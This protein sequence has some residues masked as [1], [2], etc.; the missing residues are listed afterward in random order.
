MNVT[1][2]PQHFQVKVFALAPWPAD[3]GGAIQVFHRWI[4]QG[5]LP[6]ML[7]DVAD[8]HHVPAG[9]GILLVAH[10]AHYS[11]D[12]RGNRLGLQYARRAALEGTTES[13]LR[14]AIDAAVHACRRLE[15]EPEFAGRLRFNTGELEIRVNDRLLAPNIAQTWEA[16][17]PAF[18]ACLDAIWGCGG[19]RV[20]HS[21]DAREL[22]T[23]QATAGD[24][25]PA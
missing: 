14:Q 22:L 20:R 9:P 10:E 8:Y 24:L 16:L 15:S 13:K 4:R 5:A 18:T 12:L 23:V 7:I 17:R 19:Y 2:N 11:L 25:L 1:V 3:I 21:G 6:E